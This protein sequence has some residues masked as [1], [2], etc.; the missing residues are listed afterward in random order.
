MH[1]WIHRRRHRDTTSRLRSEGTERPSPQD[2]WKNW[3]ES[4]QEHI[5]RM[6]FS[7]RRLP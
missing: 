1:L 4:L 6:S 7:E 2:N 5:I 3:R